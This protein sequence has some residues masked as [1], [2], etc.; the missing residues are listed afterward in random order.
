MLYAAVRKKDGLSSGRFW[1][2]SVVQTLQSG[3]IEAGH[4]QEADGRF[5]SDTETA[6]KAFQRAQRLLDNGVAGKA[7]WKALDEA[8]RRAFAPQRRRVV[9]N[10]RAFDG[11]LG[12]VH[13]QEGH[14]GRPYWPGGASGVTLDPGI[15]L[16][17]AEASFLGDLLRDHYG[18]LM[19]AQH[20]AA[21]DAVIGLKGDQAKAALD[22]DAVLRSI[23]IS[24]DHAD[25][26]FP[27]A[28][29]PY[30]TTIADRFPQLYDRKTP[31]SVQ[32]ALL[33]L[34]Y[35][36]GAGNRHLESLGPLLADRDW[37]AAADKI[38]DMQQSHSLK[39]IRWRR[40]EE[41]D[42]IR[43]ELEYLQA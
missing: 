41:A 18:E 42:L 2:G 30:W 11:D 19:S 20:R 10:L 32:T 21:A 40:R 17:H 27:A 38:G 43:A 23:Q 3:L 4:L 24:H 22:A 37:V 1:L 31:P 7:T 15:D 39:G 16:G 9:D 36:R 25:R 26:V 34:A 8:V 12:W 14:N 28:A 5:G 33:S 29:R 13:L 6:L 35:N